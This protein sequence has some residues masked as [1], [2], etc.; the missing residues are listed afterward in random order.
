[1]QKKVIA[2]TGKLAPVSGQYRPSGGTTEYTLS[3]GDKTPPNN[4]GKRQQF[5]L[6]DKT[7]HK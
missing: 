6:V 5:V 1:M 4:Q 3:R 7:K 2:Y